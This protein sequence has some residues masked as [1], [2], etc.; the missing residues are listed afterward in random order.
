MTPFRLTRACH[1][2]FSHSCRVG[3]RGWAVIARAQVRTHR[4]TVAGCRRAKACRHCCIATAV[5]DAP[6]LAVPGGTRG[7]PHG[8]DMRR[9]AVARRTP[10]ARRALA[11][12]QAAGCLGRPLPGALCAGAHEH[13]RKDSERGDSCRLPGILARACVVQSK[14]GAGTDTQ[15]NRK[16]SSVRLRSNWESTCKTAEPTEK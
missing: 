1:S 2:L 15:V 16:T 12:T 14:C 7:A 13:F 5:W 11:P 4:I 10:H 6:A 9:S 3:C 8:P